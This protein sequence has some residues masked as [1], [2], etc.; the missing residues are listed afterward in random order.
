MQHDHTPL[1]GAFTL[2]SG[3]LTCCPLA[4]EKFCFSVFKFLLFSSFHAQIKYHLLV[5]SQSILK[6]SGANSERMKQNLLSQP[7]INNTVIL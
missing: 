6:T 5:P 2:F 7:S 1:G 3:K 4:M